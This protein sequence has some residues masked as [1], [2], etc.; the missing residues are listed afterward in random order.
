MRSD[1]ELADLLRW[2][3]GRSD[4]Y[5]HYHNGSMQWEDIDGGD[6]GKGYGSFID[7]IEEAKTRSEAPDAASDEEVYRWYISQSLDSKK[8]LAFIEP[9]GASF[10]WYIL[11]EDGAVDSGTESVLVEAIR[12][13]Y[14]RV[15]R[16]A[17]HG[18]S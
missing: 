14:E 12:S 1:K 17:A 13:A 4:L 2:A 6:E 10:F 3:D 18:I 9:D 5:V 16:G 15:H 8:Q 7:A 11:G